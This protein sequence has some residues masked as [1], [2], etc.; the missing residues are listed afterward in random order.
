MTKK[1]LL[2]IFFFTILAQFSQAQ[3]GLFY[4]WRNINI[5]E[6]KIRQLDS[7]VYTAIVSNPGL[8]YE[9]EKHDNF[10]K[11]E[12]P[13]IVKKILSKKEFTRFKKEFEIHLS[14]EKINKTYLEKLVDENSYDMIAFKLKTLQL[15]QNQLDSIVSKEKDLIKKDHYRKWNKIDSVRI[16][17]YSKVFTN[18]QIEL[19]KQQLEL[20]KKEA[21]ELLLKAIKRQY[22]DV[23]FSETQLQSIKK[24]TFNLFEIDNFY[25]RNEIN[26]MKL[27]EFIT[28]IMTDEQLRFHEKTHHLPYNAVSDKENTDF[29]QKRYETIKAIHKNLSIFTQ[30]TIYNDLLP[31]WK[32]NYAKFDT[33]LKKQLD[34]LLSFQN[35]VNAD[36]MA[37]YNRPKKY[38]NPLSKKD[39]R[40][41]TDSLKATIMYAFVP[42]SIVFLGSKEGSQMIPNASYQGMHALDK[43]YNRIFEN[44]SKNATKNDILLESEKLETLYNQKLHAL[45]GA[46][47][48]LE[49]E[50]NFY[51]SHQKVK[52]ANYLLLGLYQINK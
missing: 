28:E 37:K 52:I 3:T 18:T 47:S 17:A 48:L 7:I 41:M 44:I 25:R 45:F 35:M 2:L 23:E 19:F 46:E 27:D 13:I 43:F 11:K 40:F 42:Q 36:Y 51:R 34:T 6:S 31:N 26:L 30:D 24:K 33:L 49:K 38:S 14:E 12:V 5:E 32:K 16:F 29:E 39:Y 4:V 50:Q 20:E 9:G 1:S 15:S 10:V 21:S 8:Q 22:K